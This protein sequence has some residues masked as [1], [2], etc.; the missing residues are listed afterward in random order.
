MR[1]LVCR[2]CTTWNALIATP[3]GNHVAD[4]STNPFHRISY[5]TCDVPHIASSDG[6]DAEDGGTISGSDIDSDGAGSDYGDDGNSNS[7]GSGKQY[8]PTDGIVKQSPLVS[9]PNKRIALR[10]ARGRVLVASVVVMVLAAYGNDPRK[11]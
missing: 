6:D 9:D 11:A 7:N 3:H 4:R 2:V 10:F 1:A 5:A 8:G